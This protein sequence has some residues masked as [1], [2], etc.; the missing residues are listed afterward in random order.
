LVASGGGGGAS[1]VAAAALDP[2]GKL[3]TA[4]F[5]VSEVLGLRRNTLRVQLARLVDAGIA[6]RVGDRH[7]IAVAHLEGRPP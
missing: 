2:A 4:C 3:D 7:R 5:H 1:G 6:H